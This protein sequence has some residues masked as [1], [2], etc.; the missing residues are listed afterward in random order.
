[1]HEIYGDFTNSVGL[2]IA[3][4]FTR[5]TGYPITGPFSAMAW[6]NKDGDMLGQAIFTDYTGANIDIHIYGPKCI[7]RKTIRDV[8]NYVF[9]R[10][11]CERLTAKLYCDNERL[12]RLLSRLGFVY[13]CTQEKYFYDKKRNL[14]VDSL[15]YKLTK[16]NIPQWVNV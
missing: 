1:M 16:D 13:E 11:N 5:N 15:V 3:S 14:I 4:Y 7:T 10:C 6:V 2:L 8:Y 12:S 9:K